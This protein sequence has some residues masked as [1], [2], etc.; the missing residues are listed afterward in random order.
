MSN[1]ISKEEMGKSNSLK[2][3]KIFVRVAESCDITGLSVSHMWQLIRENKIKSYLPSPKIRL[4]ELSSLIFYIKNNKEV[5][6]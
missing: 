2:Q 4:I 5:T 6:K 3:E 1:H